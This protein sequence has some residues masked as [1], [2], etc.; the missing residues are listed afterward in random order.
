MAADRFWGGSI[1][2]RDHTRAI[3]DRDRTRAG[4]VGK[5][6]WWIFLPEVPRQEY[7]PPRYYP[8]PLGGFTSKVVGIFLFSKGLSQ[9]SYG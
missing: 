6:G 5:P 4:L 3:V 7:P 9:N 1:V 8:P 2:Y